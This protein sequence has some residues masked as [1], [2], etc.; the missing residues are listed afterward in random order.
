MTIK[1][2]N[3]KEPSEY[4]WEAWHQVQK[5]KGRRL[6]H[7]VEQI[8]RLAAQ[9]VAKVS[10]G[11]DWV[12]ARVEEQLQSKPR[13]KA[14]VSHVRGAA[15]KGADRV[16][17]AAGAVG[18][19]VPDWV[20]T[21][22]S[23]AASSVASVSRLGLS[24]AR[25]VR[26]HQ[27]AGHD[28]TQLHHLRNLDL[29]VVDAVRG[30]AANWYY[31]AMAAASG[32]GTGAALTGGTTAVVVGAGVGAAPGAAAIAGALAVDTAA[33][34]ALSSRSVGQI[35]LSYGYDPEQP[36]EKLFV[37][38]IINAGTAA[39]SSAKYAA[40]ADVS[41]LTQALVRKKA[42]KV[43][44]DSVVTK[45]AT[46]FSSAF[47]VRL[48]QQGLGKLVPGAGMAVGATLN[49]A[50]L[51]SIVD[52][53]DVAYRWRFLADKYPHLVDES[54][55]FGGVDDEEAVDLQDV[56]ISVVD[57]LTAEGVVIDDGDEPQS[58]GD[59]RLP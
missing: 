57:V 59:V 22:A 24:P 46:K 39:T 5:F 14:V 35:A 54:A 41:K 45:V 18:G 55:A 10:E 8:N 21:S 30:R 27:K 38:A 9:G 42:W 43:L 40:F 16:S 12:G 20:G 1:E 17:D 15:A 34:V 3:V 37:L 7:G 50:T 49:W 32:V 2:G 4:E 36:E 53:A 58:P 11:A 47:G 26:K 13:A 29:E 48:T 25:V 6:S 56:D 52:A 44:N 31:P 51:E 28:V 33:I 23:A 19:R